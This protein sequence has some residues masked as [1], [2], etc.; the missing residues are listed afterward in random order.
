MGGVWQN[1]KVPLDIHR[2]RKTG[3]V[4]WCSQKFFGLRFGSKTSPSFGF[5]VTQPVPVSRVLNQSPKK[6]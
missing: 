3:L 5:Q 6:F 1:R 2:S 4:R